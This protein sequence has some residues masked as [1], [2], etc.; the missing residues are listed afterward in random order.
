[1]PAVKLTKILTLPSGK[2]SGK[3]IVVAPPKPLSRRQP[4]HVFGKKVG[5]KKVAV[6]K[7]SG[8]PALIVAASPV[9]T[10]EDEAALEE[11]KDEKRLL[12][13]KDAADIV[14]GVLFGTERE[15]AG[16]VSELVGGYL[17]AAI[18]IVFSSPSD[19]WEAILN[20]FRQA[21]LFQGNS[22]VRE[23]LSLK[24]PPTAAAI[25]G[26]RKWIMRRAGGT[27]FGSEKFATDVPVGAAYKEP[28]PATPALPAKKPVL[29][30][31]TSSPSPNARDKTAL[32]SPRATPEQRAKIM[33]AKKPV[34]RKLLK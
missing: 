2:A 27:G 5:D 6:V 13:F 26:G 29:S 23:R 12:K 22:R 14:H 10:P 4:M 34:I 18:S 11:A 31:P 8:S 16:A 25:N 19:L 21:V 30:L 9:I 33:A 17:T 1:M 7:A 15:G 20:G 28:A 32:I 24:Q 3:A